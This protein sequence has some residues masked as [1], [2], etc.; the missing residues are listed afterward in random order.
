MKE[1][2]ILIKQYYEDHSKKGDRI[3]NSIKYML[4]LES[5]WI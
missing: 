5:I 3:S 4:F 1:L 2:I